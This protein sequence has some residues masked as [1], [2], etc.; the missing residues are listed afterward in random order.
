[1]AETLILDAEAVHALAFANRRGALLDRARAILTVAHERGALVRVPVPVLAEVC[2]SPRHD[3][4]VDR[5]LNGRGIGVSDLTRPIAQRAGQLLAR[6]KL[7]STHAIEAFVVA[8][9]L[10]FE[11]ALIATGDPADIERLAAPFRQVHVLA[12]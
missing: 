2:R 12:L 10:Q 3:A 8:F 1:V 7:S 11:H 4:A 9:A 6:V 5:I